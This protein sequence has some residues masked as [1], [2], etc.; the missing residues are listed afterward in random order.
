MTLMA[1]IMISGT[2]RETPF[3]RCI[4]RDKDI[5]LKPEEI[6]H[7]EEFTTETAAK[8]TKKTQIVSTQN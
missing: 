6:V 7:Y 5:Q 2:N 8:M 3:V 4:V 1:V